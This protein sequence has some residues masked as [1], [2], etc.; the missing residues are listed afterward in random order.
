VKI[1][2]TFIQDI[3]SN[4]DMLAIIEA[5]I[6]MG[7]ALGLKV[8][9]EGVETEGRLSCFATEIAVSSKAI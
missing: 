6:S 5:I 4:R 1:D 9:A 3:N 2:R 7:H 8:T